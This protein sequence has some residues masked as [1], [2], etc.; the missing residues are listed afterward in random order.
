MRLKSASVISTEIAVICSRDCKLLI[1]M[2][3][4]PF[5]G[6]RLVGDQAIRPAVWRCVKIWTVLPWHHSCSKKSARGGLGGSWPPFYIRIT[7]PVPAGCTDRAPESRRCAPCAPLVG[8]KEES[9]WRGGFRRLV[10]GRVDWL[11]QPI[12]QIW[13]KSVSAV[14]RELF[15]LCFSRCAGLAASLRPRFG[16][17]GRLYDAQRSCRRGSQISSDK[18]G[19]AEAG[20]SVLGVTLRND[21]GVSRS[22][23]IAGAGIGSTKKSPARRR[24]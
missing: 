23:T 20:L 2:T 3:R 10:L 4:L 14:L 7:Q 18:K 13:H 16:G 22:G 21:F 9:R 5:V 15:Q 24:G 12:C 6:L 19:P 17:S 11:A 8:G 1:V